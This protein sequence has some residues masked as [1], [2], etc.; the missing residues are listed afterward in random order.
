MGLT[1][2]KQQ[3]NRRRAVACV[4]AVLLA[5]APTACSSGSGIPTGAGNPGSSTGAGVETGDDGFNLDMATVTCDDYAKS[6]AKTQYRIGTGLLNYHSKL[7]DH[8][9]SED[10]ARAMSKLTTAIERVCGSVSSGHA[11]QNG[12]GSLNDLIHWTSTNW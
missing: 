4:S 5:I 8:S 7:G 11:E 1:D 6:D 2:A 9:N 12:S 10:L 3:R